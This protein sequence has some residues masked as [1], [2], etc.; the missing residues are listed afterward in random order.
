[1]NSYSKFWSER[2]KKNLILDS[3]NFIIKIIELKF[4]LIE[5][6]LR[7]CVSTLRILIFIL[8]IKF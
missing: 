5:L 3:E 7:V 4:D 8:E 2:V 6:Y 1:M